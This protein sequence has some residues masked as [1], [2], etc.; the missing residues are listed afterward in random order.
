[1]PD[2]WWDLRNWLERV[3]VSYLKLKKLAHVFLACWTIIG[4]I[5]SCHKLKFAHVLHLVAWDPSHPCALP[6]RGVTWGEAFDYHQKWSVT[7]IP[8]LKGLGCAC[9][10][11]KLF[12]WRE[13]VVP[14]DHSEF[15][16]SLRVQHL[17]CFVMNFMNEALFYLSKQVWYTI[18]LYGLTP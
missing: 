7:T 6:S 10:S 17:M 12:H 3:R 5:V 18:F 8:S 16:T 4:E 11:C 2:M 13:T 14:D 1:M 15:L 9:K